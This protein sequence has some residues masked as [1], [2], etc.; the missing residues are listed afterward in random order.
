VSLLAVIDGGLYRSAKM[1]ARRW[2]RGFE[3]VFLHQ[4]VRCEPFVEPIA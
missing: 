4:R 1:L 2:D 3:S